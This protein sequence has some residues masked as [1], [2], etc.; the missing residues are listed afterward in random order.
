M[1][2]SRMFKNSLPQFIICPLH[3]KIP[4]TVYAKAFTFALLSTKN[5]LVIVLL[6]SP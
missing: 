5:P 1:V 3:E 6:E 2:S 4:V